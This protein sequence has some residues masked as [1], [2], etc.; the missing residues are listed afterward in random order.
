[1]S[2]PLPP[3]PPSSN[4]E[5]N[6]G[7]RFFGAL[8]MVIGTLISLLSGLC[9]LGF[10]AMMLAEP[11]RDDAAYG[12]LMFVAIVG[13]VPFLFGLAV[14]AIGRG[15]YRASRPKLPNLAKTFE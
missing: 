11:S 9:S 14:I 2:A 8:L 13:G 4:P 5:G 6:P 1:M 3:S 15:L 12:G 7:G 10:G